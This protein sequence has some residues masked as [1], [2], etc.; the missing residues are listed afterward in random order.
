MLILR[1]EKGTVLSG[2]VRV[3]HS[4]WDPAAKSYR[5]L[6]I[7]YPDITR[8][9]R[10]SGIQFQDEVLDPLPHADFRTELVPRNYQLEALDAW[11][12]AG[13]RGVAVLPT[14]SGKTVL[15]VLAIQEANCPA[16]VMVPTIDLM[17]QWRARL[18]EAFRTAVGA[19][20]GGESVLGP[21]T[22]ATYDTAY[23]RAEE[24]GNRFPLIIFDEVHHLASPGYSQIAE[25]YASPYRMGLTA[26]YEREDGLHSRLPELVGPKVYERKVSD[27]AGTHLANFRIERIQVDLPPAEAEEYVRAMGVYRGFLRRR[28]LRMHSPED[29]RRLV[30]MSGRDPEARE[31]LL[32]RMRAMEVAL[33]SNSKV[34]ALSQILEKNRGERTLIFTHHNSLVYAISASFLI[35]AITHE[36]PREERARILRKF[37]EGSYSAV[38]TSRVL[39]E[40]IDVPE[41]SLGIIL[42]GTGSKREFIQRL[43][44]LL[45]KSGDKEAR[46]IEVVSRFT[47]ESR[48]SSRRRRGV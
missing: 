1:Y 9:L 34:E 15:G 29:F 24:L 31:A 47:D 28:G 33:N 41:A 10:E 16:I 11:L 35:P 5:S 40:G 7:R 42:S 4:S 12:E 36:T 26:T 27:M 13:M 38:V 14:G 44:R 37:R 6:A 25:L 23:L 21:L 32:S 30:M 22:V 2:N 43:G 18:S 8:Y 19:Y 45:R 46:L 20:G 3:P 17:D 39:D 48:I